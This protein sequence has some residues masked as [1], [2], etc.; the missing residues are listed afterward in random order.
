MSE[1]RPGNPWTRAR[2]WFRVNRAKAEIL[3]IAGVGIGL[4]V[5]MM[6]VTLVIIVRLLR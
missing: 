1:V 5:V 4:I 6:L 3:A 2:I